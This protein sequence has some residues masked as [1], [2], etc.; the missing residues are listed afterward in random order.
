MGDIPAG[1]SLLRRWAPE[2]PGAAS[3]RVFLGDIPA[4][5]S[6]SSAGPQRSVLERASCSSAG[7]LGPSF[8]G[9]IPASAGPQSFL[10]QRLIES[11][12]GGIPGRAVL[13]PKVS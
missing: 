11:F 1:A 5:A 4:G 10:A 6:C 2:L 9:G 12:L 3:W 7:P 8:V 13:G